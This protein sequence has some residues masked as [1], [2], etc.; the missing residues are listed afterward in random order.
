MTLPLP[1]APPVGKTKA[2]KPFDP[3]SMF[4]AF[5]GGGGLGIPGFSSSANSSA[6]GQQDGSVI[7]ASPFQVGDGG[8]SSG[9]LPGMATAV[10]GAAG[11]LVPLALI[12]AVAVVAIAFVRR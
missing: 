7:W 6:Y 12:A 5:M 3:F 1:S 2:E 9:D 4:G 10:G 11:S 8:N